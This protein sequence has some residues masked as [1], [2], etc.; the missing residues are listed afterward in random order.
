MDISTFDDLLAAARAQPQPQRLL[1]VFATAELPDG[2]TAAQRAE[3]EAGAGGALVPAACVDKSPDELS[4]FEALVQEAGQFALDWRMVFVAALSG[5]TQTAPGSA[6]V[7]GALQT[8]VERIKLG[9][10]GRYLAFDRQ[11]RAIQLG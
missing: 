2:A 4:T 1:M 7:V 8:M 3:F 10:I 5:S 11:G 6:E 9:D